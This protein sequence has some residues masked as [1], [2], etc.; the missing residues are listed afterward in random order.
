MRFNFSQK[1]Y[2]R[3]Y[4]LKYSIIFSIIILLISVLID[5]GIRLNVIKP[6]IL[7]NNDHM[8]T[9]FT[10]QV[11]VSI[12]GTSVIGV[13]MGLSKEKYLGIENLSFMSKIFKIREVYLFEFL[14]LLSSYI[15]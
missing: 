13:M 8:N 12:L 1:F 11:T 3:E 5:L 7:I 2:R 4:I 6:L 15:F 9:I 14:A 10:V